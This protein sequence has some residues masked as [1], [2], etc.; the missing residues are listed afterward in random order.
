M[1]TPDTPAA[2][3]PDALL[4]VR[5]NVSVKVDP[6]ESSRSLLSAALLGLMEHVSTDGCV[7]LEAFD[8][9]RGSVAGSAQHP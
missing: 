7:D 9:S 4:D 6:S 3:A 8:I 1:S 2:S 5:I